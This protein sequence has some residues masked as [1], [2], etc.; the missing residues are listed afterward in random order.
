MCGNNHVWAIM[1]EIKAMCIGRPLYV[2]CASSFFSSLSP[3]LS[4]LFLSASIWI[5]P[6]TLTFL[7]TVLTACPPSSLL[8]LQS[9]STI[10]KSSG[11]QWN[12]VTTEEKHKVNK[13]HVPT[14]FHRFTMSLCH[15]ICWAVCAFCSLF[16]CS[17]DALVSERSKIR[18]SQKVAG[19][20]G[21]FCWGVDTTHG[22]MWK[23]R[24]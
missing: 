5:H 19:T 8:F 24:I 18:I 21:G 22:S 2:P 11:P 12:R 16:T 20:G 3:W 17:S 23:D 9:H 7:L 13:A 15:S 6:F 10:C 1:W 4:L 14:L